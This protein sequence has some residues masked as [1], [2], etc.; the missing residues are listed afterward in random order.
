M[1]ATGQ[2]NGQQERSFM[3]VAS[4]AKGESIYTKALG[5]TLEAERFLRQV[6]RLIFDSGI[7]IR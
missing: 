1:K 4:A 6:E 3:R 5:D 7:I 2:I